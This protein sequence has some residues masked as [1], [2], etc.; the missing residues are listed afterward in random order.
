MPYKQQ[1]KKS[2]W[3]KIGYA[4][5]DSGTILIGDPAYRDEFN[6]D[7]DVIKGMKN[8][9]V[10]RLPYGRG[11]IV[12]TMHGDGTYPVYANK[13]MSEVKIKLGYPSDYK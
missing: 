2:S 13:N 7:R 4:R 3:K 12:Q 6:C 1:L 10:N 11:V 8:K 9:G 5:V